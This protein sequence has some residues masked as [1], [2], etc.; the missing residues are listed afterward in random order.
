MSA[1]KPFAALLLVSSAACSGTA[2]SSQPTVSSSAPSASSA[3]VSGD[4]IGPAT[5]VVRT[6][7][8]DGESVIA[9]PTGRPWAACTL[10]A[11]EASGADDALEVFADD[12]GVARVRARPTDPRA[13][14]APMRLD[15]ADE[16]GTFSVAVDIVVDPA[17]PRSPPMPAPKGRVR[18]A[19][20]EDPTSLTPEEL[21]AR[22]FPPR[23]DP[24]GD[25]SRYA[26]WLEIASRRRF[27]RRAWGATDDSTR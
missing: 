3:Y 8:P 2:G 6:I 24:V 20:A 16:T 19:L 13:S 10:D 26:S 15:C 25:P 18:P 9:I 22:G 27:E 7:R 23:P 17:A 4:P 21:V 11:A 5:R 12:E 1:L 14:T